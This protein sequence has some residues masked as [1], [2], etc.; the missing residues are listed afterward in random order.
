MKDII[1][2]APAL[3][4]EYMLIRKEH[5]THL[6]RTRA[7]TLMAYREMMRKYRRCAIEL[8]A[9]HM[10]RQQR[11]LGLAAPQTHTASTTGGQ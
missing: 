5:L 8:H 6:Y 1:R 11:V 4:G 7:Q 3:P 10:E 9:F 2:S